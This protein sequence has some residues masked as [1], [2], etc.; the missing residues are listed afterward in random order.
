MMAQTNSYS[1]TFRKKDGSDRQMRFV[2]MAELTEQQKSNIGLIP[3]ASAN[4]QIYLQPG[5]EIVYDLDAKEFR[6]FNWNATVGEVQKQQ[7]EF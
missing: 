3:G 2:R 5:F 1:G 7:I 4:R 6:T